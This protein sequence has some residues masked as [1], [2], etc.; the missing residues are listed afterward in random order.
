MSGVEHSL[1]LRERYD[2]CLQRSDFSGFRDIL[3]G[4]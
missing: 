3:R 4:F 1:N 2:S